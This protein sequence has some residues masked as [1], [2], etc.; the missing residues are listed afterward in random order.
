MIFDSTDLIGTSARCTTLE[1]GIIL[2]GN[3]IVQTTLLVKQEFS[4]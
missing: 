4:E 2:T 3:I 1:F